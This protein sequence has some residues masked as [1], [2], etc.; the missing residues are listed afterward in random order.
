MII[1]CQDDGYTDEPFSFIW[2]DTEK[3]YKYW[4][5]IYEAY[6]TLQPITQDMILQK[7]EE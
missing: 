7:N 3:G 5:K 2:E 4:H 1:K 6:R